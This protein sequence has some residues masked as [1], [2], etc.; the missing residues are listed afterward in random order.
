MKYNYIFSLVNYWFSKICLCF[1]RISNIRILLPAAFFLGSCVF[2]YGQNKGTADTYD[3]ASSL[4]L[5]QCIDFAFKHQPAYQ[6]SFINQSIAKANNAINL[7]GFYP[8]V[9]ATG[10][11]TYYIQRPTTYIAGTNTPVKSGVENALTI[12]G[13]SVTQSVFS[14]SLNYA[15]KAAPLLVK[16][17]VQITD[18]SKIEIVSAVSK[19]FYSLLLTLQQIEVLKQDTVILGQS[20]RDAYHQY[21]GGIVDETDYEEAL[22]SLNNAVIQLKQAT[23]NI[24]PQYAILKQVMGYPPQNQFDVSYD[25]TAMAGSIALDTTEQLRFEKR[26]EYQQ[27]ATQMQLQRQLTAYYQ[28]AWQPTIS[29][30]YNYGLGFENNSF[31]KLFSSAYPSSYIG[32]SL[33]MPIFTGFAR[34]QNVRKSK[35]QEKLI[36]WGQVSLKSQI[37]TEY[38]SALANYKS[39]F[40]SLNVLQDNIKMSKRVYFVVELQY[41]QGI[42]P[43]LNVITAQ[44]NLVTSEINY[45]NALFQTLSSKI[46]LEKAMGDIPY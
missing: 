16:E 36:D 6:Q 33:S 10:N 5:E 25:S 31:S 17:A 12:P 37:Y 46:D 29:A 2:G 14:P 15:M 21:K 13:I 4:T 3:T 11:Y 26:I 1:L 23:E 35:L 18:S 24:L 7:S 9:A 42:V 43:Y 39:N 19:S 22:V 34:V 8:Q 38:A 40:Y 44:S 28:Q 27:L 32:I 45:Y 41:K 30:S 20:Y